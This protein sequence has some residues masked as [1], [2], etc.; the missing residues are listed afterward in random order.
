[1]VNESVSPHPVIES[2]NRESWAVAFS[3][4]VGGRYQSLFENKSVSGFGRGG[5]YVQNETEGEILEEWETRDDT[6]RLRWF[7]VPHS[8]SSNRRWEEARCPAQLIEPK[9]GIERS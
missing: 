6:E 7:A 3:V 9:V 4:E 1:M 2:S 5:R 8:E